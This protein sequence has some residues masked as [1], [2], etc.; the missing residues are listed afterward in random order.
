[1]ALGLHYLQLMPQNF[2]M[3]QNTWRFGAGHVPAK[4]ASAVMG[5]LAGKTESWQVVETWSGTLMRDA[6]WQATSFTSASQKFRSGDASTGTSVSVSP[7]LMI[8]SSGSTS[9]STSLLL[10]GKLRGRTSQ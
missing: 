9:V 1:M 8:S 6:S 3:L 5:F 4:A 10:A 2:E 7:C